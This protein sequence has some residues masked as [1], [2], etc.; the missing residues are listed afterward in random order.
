MPQPTKEEAE[1]SKHFGAPVCFDPAFDNSPI[2]REFIPM[3][4]NTK[5]D[6]AKRLKEIFTAK[7]KRRHPGRQS[8]LLTKEASVILREAAKRIDRSFNKTAS[9]MVIGNHAMRSAH[10]CI[11]ANVAKR[12]E[13]PNAFPLYGFDHK[14]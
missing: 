3:L 11:M 12:K 5:K 14:A 1:L 6:T 2:K 8:V 10:E 9:K 13:Q 4:P 7:P